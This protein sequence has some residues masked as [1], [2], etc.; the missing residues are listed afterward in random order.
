MGCGSSKPQHGS[1]APAPRPIPLQAQPGSQSHGGRSEIPGHQAIPRPTTPPNAASGSH[2][3]ATAMRGEVRRQFM[4]T[5]HA[6]LHDVPYMVIGG[7]ALAEYGSLRETA[8]VDVLVGEGISKGSAESLL[9]KRG[10]GRIVRLGQGKLGYISGNGRVYPLDLT[11]DVDVD[12]PFDLERDT[13]LVCGTRVATV[14]FLL[15]SKAH[16]WQTRVPFEP[17][18]QEKREK[19]AND[20]GFCLGL[21]QGRRDIGR[22][23]LNWVYS[24]HFWSPF[25]AA[26]PR[27]EPLFRG[28]GLWTDE[29][30]FSSD[31]SVA[32]RSSRSNWSHPGSFHSQQGGARGGYN[33][34]GSSR[35]GSRTGSMGR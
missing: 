13:Q 30:D 29:T 31:S 14:V 26:K 4:E 24:R 9:I 27:M 12:L 10:Q 20:I 3:Q 2:G 19:D 11:A 21:L 7:S 15:N 18:Y 23:R 17:D 16:A 1:G 25:L 34:M 6:A 22:R 33:S 8:D 28:A 32:G 5:V 35:A